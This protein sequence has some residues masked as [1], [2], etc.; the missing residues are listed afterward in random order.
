[1]DN[2][3]CAGHLNKNPENKDYY[4]YYEGNTSKKKRGLH[5][6][7]ALPHAHIWESNGKDD[8]DMFVKPPRKAICVSYKGDRDFVSTDIPDNLIEVP[9]DGEGN[10]KCSRSADGTITY[11]K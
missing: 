5:G 11:Y 4:L 2:D 8:M 3:F 10:D 9:R 7:D 1:M 6:T